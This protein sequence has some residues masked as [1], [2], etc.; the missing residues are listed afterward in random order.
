LIHLGNS[1]KEIKLNVAQ[2][3]PNVSLTENDVIIPDTFANLF[4]IEKNE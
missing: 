2:G 3:F 4:N 1:N